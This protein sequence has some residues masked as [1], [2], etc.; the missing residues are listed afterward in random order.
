MREDLRVNEKVN[1][2][3]DKGGVD[4]EDTEEVAVEK[5][6]TVVN[7]AENF[8]NA[9]DTEQ[10]E[11]ATGK[12][13]ESISE[14]EKRCADYETKICEMQKDFALQLALHK[15]GA[16]SVKAAAALIDRAAITLDD[17]G[18]AVGITEQIEALKADSETAFLF[19][20]S[21]LKGL[22]PQENAGQLTAENDSGAMTYA[23]LCEIYK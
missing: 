7:E 5:E 1:G 12:A 17:G 2:G 4:R 19:N 16:R 23:Q 20:G 22:V 3:L 6:T 14:L 9:P 10:K 8:G 13:T 11:A 15:A 21:S 18:N